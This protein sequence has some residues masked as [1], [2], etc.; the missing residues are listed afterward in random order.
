MQM[1]GGT[2]KS[3]VTIHR[4]LD[5]KVNIRMAALMKGDA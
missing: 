1:E 2:R 3:G 4:G 5:R